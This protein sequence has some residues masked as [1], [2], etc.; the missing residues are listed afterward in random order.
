MSML[1][2]SSHYQVEV[3]LPSS[4]SSPSRSLDVSSNNV[5]LKF[6]TDQ[7]TILQLKQTLNISS[8]ELIF[9][10]GKRLKDGDKVP[11]DS[12]RKA[13]C[14]LMGKLSTLPA[15]HTK[16]TQG[17]VGNEGT[18]EANRNLEIA[19]FVP[20]ETRTTMAAVPDLK[21][22]TVNYILIKGPEADRVTRFALSKGL[23]YKELKQLFV[24]TAQ[25]PTIVVARSIRFIGK[26]G[27]EPADYELLPETGLVTLRALRTERGHSEVEKLQE[28]ANIKDKIE[29]AEREVGK[30]V[31][32]LYDPETCLLESRRIQTELE[33]SIGWLDDKSSDLK[34]R[35]QAVI[36]RLRRL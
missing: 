15:T 36:N 14:R 29:V 2:S 18:I 4:A 13:K 27:K 33:D 8:G 31:N 17:T 9:Q 23:T 5:L 24:S 1:H 12:N 21:E 28:M 16:A 32:R 30:I 25:D 35:A 3:V 7:T 11:F 26:G 22:A 10:G 34:D 19:D 20:S 6:D